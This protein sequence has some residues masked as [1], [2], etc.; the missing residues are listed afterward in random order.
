MAIANDK[1]SYLFGQVTSNSHNVA[2]SNQLAL[3]MK[4]LGI[5]NDQAGRSLLTESLENMVQNS[6][7]ITNTFTKGS[8]NFE[9][10][11]ALFAGHSGKFG[12][13]EATFEVMSD[14]TRRFTTLIIKGVE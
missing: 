12:V 5:F 2:R 14:N 6:K 4:R 1:F 7:N 8:Q 3:Q 11:Q 9:T 13:F 10:R